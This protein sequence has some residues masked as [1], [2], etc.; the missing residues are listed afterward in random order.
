MSAQIVISIG[1]R[2]RR[3]LPIKAEVSSDCIITGY[4]I[5]IYQELF[6]CIFRLDWTLHLSLPFVQLIFCNFALIALFTLVQLLCI[7]GTKK[8]A[9]PER[10]KVVYLLALGFSLTGGTGFPNYEHSKK[11]LMPSKKIFLQQCTNVFLRF[12]YCTCSSLTK[13]TFIW[14]LKTCI[15][16]FFLFT[17][18]FIWLFLI[19]KIKQ[20]ISCLIY[21]LPLSWFST[22]TALRHGFIALF[23]VLV[24]CDHLTL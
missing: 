21:H 8:A 2:R 15:T 6:R 19:L 12:I 17:G 11:F 1:N 4:G 20:G 23:S 14:L 16:C 9:F 5:T 22:V 24:K 7:Q 10:L 3:T 13:M 18:N